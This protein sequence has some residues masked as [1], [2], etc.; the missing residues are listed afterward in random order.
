MAVTSNE[1]IKQI[2]ELYVKNHTY[3]AVAREL[4][5][6]P[7]TVKKY[8]LPNYVPED[9]LILTHVDMVMCKARIEHYILP[10]EAFENDTIMT[11][12]DEEKKN[13]EELWKEISI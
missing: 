8:V 12:T 4:G 10:K 3:A 7:A 1:T 13:V 9:A 5:V 6:S 11:L 2:N